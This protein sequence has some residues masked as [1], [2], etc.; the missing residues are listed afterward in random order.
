MPS[1]GVPGRA[2]SEGGVLKSGEVVILY[3]AGNLL[4]AEKSMYDAGVRCRLLSFAEIDLWGK[5]AFEF[6]IEN[7]PPD[8]R[9]FLD[10]G[11]YGAFT[12]GITIDI[13]RYCEYIKEH[14]DKLHTVAS[15]DKIGDW[16][17]SARNYDLMRAEGVHPVPTVHMGSPDSELRRILALEDHIALGGVVGATQNTMSPWLDKCM[18][19]LRDFWPKKVHIF[20]VTA[21]W[22]LERYPF[23]TADSSAAIL[24]GGMGRVSAFVEGKVTV[25]GWQDYAKEFYD[26]DV[27][28]H[29]ANVRAKKGSA[30][31]GRRAINVS[32]QLKLQAH[33]TNVWRKRG[34]VWE[35]ESCA[36]STGLSV[37]ASTNPS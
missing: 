36:A 10:S 27:M 37:E 7:K 15:L 28:D 19:T 35:G 16:R 24:G 30:H 25:M 1:R 11:A 8:V 23:Y 18:R 32:G 3:F 22:A 17:G 31:V 2:V 14:A 33:I 34:I 9:I 26:G 5:D 21:Q 4:S 13:K 12:R 20:G 29:I 6:W